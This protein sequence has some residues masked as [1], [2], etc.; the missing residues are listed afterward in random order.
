MYIYASPSSGPNLVPSR[1]REVS[2]IRRGAAVGTLFCPSK[3]CLPKTPSTIHEQKRVLVLSTTS[4]NFFWEGG[5]YTEGESTRGT[6]Q[7]DLTQDDAMTH[8]AIRHKE[9]NRLTPSTLHTLCKHAVHVHVL[10][11]LIAT[12]HIHIYIYIYIYVCIYIYIYN[13]LTIVTV[14]SPSPVPSHSL[15]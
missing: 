2:G 15:S 5:G 14:P 9:R 8:S 6:T 7:S 1:P 13:V 4:T 10:S 3:A 11:T 12:S